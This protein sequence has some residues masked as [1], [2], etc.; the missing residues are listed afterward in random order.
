MRPALPTMVDV[1]ITGESRDCLTS[2]T[3][4][5]NPSLGSSFLSDFLFSFGTDWAEAAGGRRPIIARAPRGGISRACVTMIAG[6]INAGDQRSPWGESLYA[7]HG[8]FS[9]DQRAAAGV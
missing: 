2:A 8:V 9:H 3:A 4:S 6:E 5:R 7:M 1:G